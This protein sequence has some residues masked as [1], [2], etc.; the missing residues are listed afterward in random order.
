MLK[1]SLF[2]SV[3]ADRLDEN[4]VSNIMDIIQRRRSTHS[5]VACVGDDTKLVRVLVLP[6]VADYDSRSQ[7]LDRGKENGNLLLLEMSL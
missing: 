6:K 3:T 5:T 1:Y 4:N 7:R 2:I